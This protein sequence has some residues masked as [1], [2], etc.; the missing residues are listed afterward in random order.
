VRAL[1][2]SERLTWF[3]IGAAAIVA[4]SWVCSR[5]FVVTEE[6]YVRMLGRCRRCK[7]S[8]THRPGQSGVARQLHDQYDCEEETA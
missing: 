3:L 8:Y 7:R 6:G 5:H 2:R 4:L 1:D